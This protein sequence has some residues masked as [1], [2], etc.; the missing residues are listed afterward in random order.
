[1]LVFDDEYHVK[2][3]Q[4]GGHEVNVVLPLCV[5][6]AAKH[7]VSRSQHRAARVQR[8]GDASLRDGKVLFCFIDKEKIYTFFFFFNLSNRDGLLLHGL[9]DGHSVVL[10]HLNKLV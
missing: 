7:R 6:P 9:M 3:G 10:S 4:D 8:G 2:A 5:I 1:M